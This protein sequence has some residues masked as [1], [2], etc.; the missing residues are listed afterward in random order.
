MGGEAARAA[1]ARRV[2]GPRRRAARQ[3]R[4]AW[5]RVTS[6][7]SVNARLHFTLHLTLVRDARSLVLALA[8]RSDCMRTAPSSARRAVGRQG[9]RLRRIRLRHFHLRFVGFVVAGLH[10]AHVW[11]GERRR[12]GRGCGQGRGCEGQGRLGHG[13]RKGTWRWC[14]ATKSSDSSNRSKVYRSIRRNRNK[15]IDRS[16]RSNAGVYESHATP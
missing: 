11:L 12:E 8:T 9:Q 2:V 4:R 3:V 16:N 13:T 14:A 7:G 1:A 15:R 10:V 5:P 6:A